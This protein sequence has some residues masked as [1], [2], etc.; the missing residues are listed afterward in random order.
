MLRLGRRVRIRLL[1]VDS[2]ARALYPYLLLVDLAIYYMVN[3]VL[4]ALRRVDV[5]I[6]DRFFLDA[7][8]DAVHL[9]RGINKLLLKLCLS[10]H[11]RVGKSIVLDV[12][13]ETALRRKRDIIPAKEVSFKRGLYLILSKS[14]GLATI[15][16]SREL[17]NVLEEVLE[18]VDPL[19]IKASGGQ[20]IDLETNT[21]FYPSYLHPHTLPY[22]V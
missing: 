22:F 10:M 8:I 16:S 18:V 5:V 19:A 3:R 14:L 13:V 1:H 7:L 15:D 6:Y 21:N 17:R 12:N 2:V 11:R 4:Q 20:L 9:C